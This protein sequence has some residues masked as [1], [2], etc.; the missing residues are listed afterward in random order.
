MSKQVATVRV[1]YLSFDHKLKSVLVV[2]N[3]AS[4]YSPPKFY[5]HALETMGCGKNSSSIEGAA[6]EL[7]SDH[8]RIFEVEVI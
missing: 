4:G 8:G 7:V 3:E 1:N 6:R 5:A 2:V